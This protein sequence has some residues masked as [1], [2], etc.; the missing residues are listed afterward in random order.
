[1]T[2]EYTLSRGASPTFEH[3]VT[4]LAGELVDLTDAEI[5]AVV[6]DLSGAIVLEHKSLAAGGSSDEIEIPDQATDSGVDKGKFRWKLTSGVTSNLEQTAR[7]ADVWVVTA[8][9]E[10]ET[11]KV[12][13][14]VPF[15]VTGDEPPDFV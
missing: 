5:Y 8:A 14:R 15:Y 10:P 4:S 2:T 13:E 7:W 1:M 12:A 3:T 11:L 6:R 9:D